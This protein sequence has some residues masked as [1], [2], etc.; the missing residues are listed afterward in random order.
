MAIS[1][2]MLEQYKKLEV[3]DID[4]QVLYLCKNGMFDK[5]NLFTIYQQFKTAIHLN[6]TEAYEVFRTVL[7]NWLD[8]SEI[9]ILKNTL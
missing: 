9:D 1:E 7:K 8:D 4:K 5:I 3:T 2:N 6:D